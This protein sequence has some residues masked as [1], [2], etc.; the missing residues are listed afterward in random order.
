MMKINKLLKLQEIIEE[1]KR[2]CDLYTVYQYFSTSK[3]E[4]IDI[5]EMHLNHFLR[6]AFKYIPE[7]IMYARH[8]D[9]NVW[10]DNN[11]K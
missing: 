9:D 2:P 3:E 5:G 11:E 6:V 1:R 4:W 10:E 7:D 8:E